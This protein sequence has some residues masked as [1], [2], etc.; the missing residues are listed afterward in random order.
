MRGGGGG[1]RGRHPIHFFL[2]LER[3]HAYAGGDGDDARESRDEEE[4]K[5]S[6]T[7]Q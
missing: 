6:L 3:V 1:A 2:P 7:F 4:E 5:L